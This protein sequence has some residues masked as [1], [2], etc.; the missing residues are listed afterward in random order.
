LFKDCRIIATDLSPQLLAILSRYLAST[1]LEASVACVCTDAMN[2]F[3]KASKF[4]LVTG[5]A[6]LHH[7]MDPTAALRS[8]YRALRPGGTAIFFEPFEAGCMVLATAFRDILAMNENR[9]D[10]SPQVE[11]IFRDMILDWTTRAG[12]DKSAPHFPHMD[13]K[14]LFTRTYLEQA[15]KNIGFSDLKLVPHAHGQH[16]FRG[17]TTTVLRL[18]SGLLPEAL[19]PW[20]WEMIDAIDKSCSDELKAELSME[21]TIVLRK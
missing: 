6:I 12:T 5:A 1:K 20:A 3:F 9:G 13:D 17:Q 21:A 2:D 8:A 15:A 14:W 19:P 11:K 10:L 4:D 16:Q 18:H 7:L